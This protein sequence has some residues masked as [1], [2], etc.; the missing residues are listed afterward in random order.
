[1]RQN[2]VTDVEHAW[3]TPWDIDHPVSGSPLR[4]YHLA[5][6]VAAALGMT[7]FSPVEELASSS[8]YPPLAGRIDLRRHE[9]GTFGRLL[10]RT[11]LNP[12]ARAARGPALDSFCRHLARRWSQGHEHWVVCDSAYLAPPLLRLAGATGAR[13]IYCSH[14][15]E[16]D[17]WK[18][19]VRAASSATARAGALLAY[20][21]VR[22][23][24]RALLRAASATWC[25]SSVDAGFMGTLAPG[26]AGSI[27]VVPNGVNPEIVPVQRVDAIEPDTICFI[28]YLGAGPVHETCMLLIDEV[29]PRIRAARPGARLL[30]A[31]RDAR[32]QLRAR[33]G[34]GTEVISPLADPAAVLRRARASVVPQFQGGGT[35]IKIIESLAAGR[36]VVST[37][38]GAEGLLVDRLPGITIADSVLEL[39][40]TVVAELDRPLDQ[41]R[42]DEL[43]SHAVQIYS[44]DG[45]IRE[46]ASEMATRFPGQWRRAAAVSA[47]AADRHPRTGDERR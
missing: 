15:C 2:R 27:I 24:E 28:G 6:G 32:P 17:V 21:E 45:I 44:W 41:A 26:S 34:G 42:A 16:T 12:T 43:R 47:A 38:K 23:Q 9:R 11:I 7:V 46:L 1:V 39:A 37:S 22:R 25:C 19:L 20:W 10:G 3:F 18:Q 40:S 31:G 36:P 35:R 33:A 29:L 30:L 4:S 5:G 13:L 8:P 14:N